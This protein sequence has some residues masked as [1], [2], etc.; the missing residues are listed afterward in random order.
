MS[1]TSFNKINKQREEQGK[2]TFANPRNATA[3]TLKLLDSKEV[4][5]RP[6]SFLAHG[7]GDYNGEDLENDAAFRD[8]LTQLRI[9]NNHPIWKVDS[10]ETML[11][12]IQELDEKRHS[13][14]HAT[15]GAVVKISDFNLRNQLGA[16]SRA[17]RWAAAFKYPPEQKETKLLN[18]TVQ[19]GRTG[20]LTPVA[21]LEPVHVS[22]TTVSRATLH[23]E[24][25]ISR[26]DVRIGDTVVIEKAGEII[27]SVV[28]VVLKKRPEDS[29]PFNFFNYLNGKCP[30]CNEGIVRE[31]GFTAWKCVNF[32][33]P[34]KAATRLTHFASRKA[35]DLDGLGDSV[36]IRL[37]D[38]GLVQ[39]IF[40]IFRLNHSELADLEL[41]PAK[42]QDG[43]LSKPR[44]FGAKRA[45][46]LIDSMQRAISSVPLSKWIYGIGIPHIGESASR[47]VSR[48]TKSITEISE[49]KILEQLVDLSDLKIAQQQISP[50][51]KSNPPKDDKDKQERQQQFNTL[52]QKI[53]SLEDA[54]KP[55]QISS[56]LGP[57]AARVLH[58]FFNSDSGK[59]LVLS[60]KDLNIKPASDNYAPL[61]PEASSDQPF[62]GKTFVITG[63]LSQPRGDFK[64]QIENLG[65]KVSGSVSKNTDYLLSGEGGGSKYSK[66]E[67]LNIPILDEKAY[68]E[69]KRNSE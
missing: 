25:E 57:V 66:A 24:D 6:L 49:S 29:Q 33:C 13:F 60:L 36:A 67:S 5:Q 22:G 28:K 59:E 39:N 31:K 19:V 27:P 53:S 14:D 61:P 11:A 38:S 58:Q 65:G 42:M 15:D 48:L 55:Y 26:K 18:I 47:E 45:Q 50:R 16:T 10:L 64:K 69:L 17:P 21:E 68:L 46:S 3:G 40:D 56:E 30:S 8:L 43:S 2:E 12:A 7:I 51:N 23:N 32:A 9:P 63:T 52:K 34:A 62:V 1:F 41:E 37:I 20:N 54:L 35:L 44:Q 4:A